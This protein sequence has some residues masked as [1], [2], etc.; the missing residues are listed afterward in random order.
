MCSTG[1]ESVSLKKEHRCGE[2]TPLAGFN[3]T[4]GNGQ[5]RERKSNKGSKPKEERKDNEAV[6]VQAV[7]GNNTGGYSGSCLFLFLL[8]AHALLYC[9]S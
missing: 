6:N 8:L 1:G 4:R 3:N 5:S 9:F 2:K 7:V